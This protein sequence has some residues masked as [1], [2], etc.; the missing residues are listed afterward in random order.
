MKCL[1]LKIFAHKCLGFPI[2]S[3]FQLFGFVHRHEG[4]DEKKN[5]VLFTLIFLIQDPFSPMTVPWRKPYYVS[6]KYLQCCCQVVSRCFNTFFTHTTQHGHMFHDKCFSFFS[7]VFFVFVLHKSESGF[8]GFNV[9]FNSF[10][11]MFQR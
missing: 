5:N 8:W 7:H 2:A 4:R 11:H 6:S 9:F 3:V 10:K 1:G